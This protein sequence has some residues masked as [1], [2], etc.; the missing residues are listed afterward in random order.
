MTGTR[1]PSLDPVGSQAHSATLDHKFSQ[2]VWPVV[3]VIAPAYSDH[4]QRNGVL[5][6]LCLV[7][8]DFN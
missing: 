5:M 6:F 3:V 1:T 8:K 2:I 4:S 7:A